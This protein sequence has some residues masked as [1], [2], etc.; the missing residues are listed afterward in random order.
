MNPCIINNKI[1]CEASTAADQFILQI[2]AGVRRSSWIV[3][4][5]RPRCT[6]SQVVQQIMFIQK[7]P[8]NEWYQ[9]ARNIRRGECAPATECDTWNRN[10]S[11]S[12]ESGESH[13][14][15]NPPEIFEKIENYNEF[16]GNKS[17]WDRAFHV[18]SLLGMKPILFKGQTSKRVHKLVGSVRYGDGSFAHGTFLKNGLLHT[19]TG[20]V[21]MERGMSRDGIL[22]GVLGDATI[23][24]P[25]W[26]S[27]FPRGLCSIQFSVPSDPKN[28][29]MFRGTLNELG[30]PNTC[31]AIRLISERNRDDEKSKNIVPDSEKRIIHGCS[32]Y[33]LPKSTS[34][35]KRSRCFKMYIYRHP[36]SSDEVHPRGIG[37]AIVDIFDG[38]NG[39][40]YRVCI[41]GK[42]RFRPNY[43][44]VGKG[45]LDIV[46]GDTYSCALNLM[47]PSQSETAATAQDLRHGIEIYKLNQL[48]EDNQTSAVNE[49]SQDSMYAYEKMNLF[50]WRIHRIDDIHRLIS[51]AR[52]RIGEVTESLYEIVRVHIVHRIS[53]NDSVSPTFV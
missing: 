23:Y 42:L 45:H 38:L 44:Y 11:Q 41:R 34:L 27:G 53:C 10:T 35:Q 37:H 3:M 33:S 46:I 32:I 19:F 15:W 2:I 17:T 12:S 1:V 6:N 26:S 20:F 9:I 48:Q 47:N 7:S 29:L 50:E 28:R 13:M 5:D 43:R 21:D 31:S 18:Q 4:S 51:T 52:R 25:V 39:E 22:H 30:E 14:V 40:A 49:T 8:A 36:D 16:L 24:S